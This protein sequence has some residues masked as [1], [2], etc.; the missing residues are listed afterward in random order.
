[1]LS[2]RWAALGLVTTLAAVGCA[3]LPYAPR[4]PIEVARVVRPGLANDGKFASTLV[5]GDQLLVELSDGATSRQI[6]ATVDGRGSVHVTSG[7]DVEVAGL[8]LGGAEARLNG[9]IRQVEK[10]TD[11]HVRLA[12]AVQRRVNVFGAVANPGFVPVKPGMRVIDVVADAGGVL[13]QAATTPI[14]Q[15]K[16]ADLEGAVLVRKGQVVPISL[17]RALEGAAGHN[18]YVHP[19]DYLYVPFE[20]EQQISVFGQVGSPRIVEYRRG[21][22]LSE[23]LSAAGGI[24]KNGDKGDIRLVRGGPVAPD[25]F[26]ASLSAI[27]DGHASDV[28]LSPGD[29]LF[30]EDHPIEDFREL[31]PIVAGVVGVAVTVLTSILIAKRR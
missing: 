10:F 3:G 30:V 5:P 2:A 20:S 12:D 16:M 19:G 6:Q 27:V 17:K 26:R 25:V 4:F 31:L 13:N 11:V 15:A 28:V 9:A 7:K 21:L 22:R 29:V 1:M 18:V 23:A 24:T 8:S 14:T